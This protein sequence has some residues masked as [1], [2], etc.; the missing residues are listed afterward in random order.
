ML[1]RTS[2]KWVTSGHHNRK[3]SNR[4]QLSNIVRIAVAIV[5]I[6]LLFYGIAELALYHALISGIIYIIIGAFLIWLGYFVI[7]FPI[8]AKD[9]RLLQPRIN[10]ILLYFSIIVLLNLLLVLLSSL[11]SFM[12][13]TISSFSKSLSTY[14]FI[15]HRCL[16]T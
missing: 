15:I 6:I 4:L 7:R 3:M 5:G 1:G 11:M 2:Y 14:I 13:W 12:W 9:L 10:K 8:R 16:H